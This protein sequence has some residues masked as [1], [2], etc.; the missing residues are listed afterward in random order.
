MIK[1]NP[2]LIDILT[3]FESAPDCVQGDRVATGSLTDVILQMSIL[4]TSCFSNAVNRTLKC[5]VM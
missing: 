5:I 2:D 1:D 3:S 4:R